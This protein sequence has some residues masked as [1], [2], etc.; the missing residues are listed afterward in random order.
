MAQSKTFCSSSTRISMAKGHTLLS[1]SF[2][3]FMLIAVS[4][5]LA[6][7]AQA[8]H[9]GVALQTFWAKT[10]CLM[11]FHFALSLD[12]TKVPLARIDTLLLITTFLKG[13][14]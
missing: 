13:A 9:N 3:S 12:P 1:V 11:V 10:T 6:A 2:T 8:L 4:I 5:F 14:V 7:N